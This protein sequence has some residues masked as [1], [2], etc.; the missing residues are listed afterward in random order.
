MIDIDQKNK[1]NEKVYSASVFV[2]NFI[3]HAVFVSV[4]YIFHIAV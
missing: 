4:Q 2:T 3:V 1:Y